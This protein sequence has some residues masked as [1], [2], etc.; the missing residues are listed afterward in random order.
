MDNK[1]KLVLINFLKTGLSTRELDNL[2]GYDK[3]KT[4]GWKS[5]EILKKYN[6]KNKDKG[7]LFLYSNSHCLKFIKKLKEIELDSLIQKNPPRIVKKYS[8]SKILAE[9][10]I[11]FYQVMNGETRNIIQGFFAPYKKIVHVCQFEGCK[12]KKLDTVHLNRERPEIL[13][14][15]AKE[16]G[17]KKQNYFEYPIMKVMIK[18][19]KSHQRKGSICFLCKKHHLELHRLEKI[20]NKELKSFKKKIKFV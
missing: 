12:N 20:S 5:F 13:K 4:K 8:N 11:K 2:I 15:V 3:I 16:L 9:D 10:E 18:F 14:D 19:L 7:K 17:M 1:E 6:L